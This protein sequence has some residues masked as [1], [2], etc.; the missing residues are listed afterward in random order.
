MHCSCTFNEGA[1][2]VKVYCFRWCLDLPA[3]TRSRARRASAAAFTG[4][5]DM[6][7]D[8]SFARD[9]ILNTELLHTL[10]SIETVLWLIFGLMLVSQFVTYIQARR[11]TA[12]EKKKGG[13]EWGAVVESAYES[14][15]YNDALQT[16]ATTE[17]LF[18][19]SAIVK[20]WQGRCHFQLEAWEKA[21]E[22]FQEC[23]RLEPPYRKSV[24]D[25]M[26]FIELNELV[27]GVEGYLK[28]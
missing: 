15:R 5:N 3:P 7:R 8:L 19:R 26:A 17:V 18:P 22:K 1:G 25:Y 28:K 21:A 11:R 9:L 27:A 20:F 24:R 2:K 4:L 14:G 23:C 10:R 6:N 16:L 13:L 12:G